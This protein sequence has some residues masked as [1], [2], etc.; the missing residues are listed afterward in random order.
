MFHDSQEK[1]KD[2]FQV[3]LKDIKQATGNFSYENYIGS[4]EFSTAYRGEVTHANGHTTSIVVKRFIVGCEIDYNLA[5]ELKILMEHKHENVIALLGY[6]VEGNERIIVYEHAVNGSLDRYLNDVSLTWEKRLK[7]CI[8]I[9]SGLDFLHGGFVTGEVVI[10]RDIKSRNILL[11]GNMNAKIAN[12]GFSVIRPVDQDTILLDTIAGTLSYVDPEY[13]RTCLLSK[14]CD[15]YSF[16]IVL[17][18]IMFRRLAYSKEFAK[19]DFLGPLI[20]R[21]YKEGKL[22]EMVFEGTSEQIAQQSLTIFRRI[23]IQCLHEKREERPTAREVVIQLK[24]ALEIQVS[25]H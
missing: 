10:H 15:I 13:R 11:D 19:D 23:A 18:E 5:T 24:K 16:G 25:F 20:K 21:L 12:F 8:D 7:I 2:V 14:E 22:D 6:C 1:R 17:F 4:G 3:S 9:A